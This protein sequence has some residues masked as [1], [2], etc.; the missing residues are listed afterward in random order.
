M[1]STRKATA[2]CENEEKAK[3][4]KYVTMVARASQK[5]EE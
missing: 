3:K 4:R 5:K 2:S 1:V